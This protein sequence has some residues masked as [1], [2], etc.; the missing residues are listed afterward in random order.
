MTTQA[1]L[2]SHYGYERDSSSNIVKG[3]DLEWLKWDVTR[4]MSINSALS[5][6]AHQGYRVASNNE[7]TALFQHFKFGR[8]DWRATSNYQSSETDWSIGEDSEYNAFISLFGA[9]YKSSCGI[10]TRYCYR[11]TDPYEYTY[12]QY[13]FDNKIR[14]YAYAIVSDDSTYIEYDLSKGN[15][16]SKLRAGAERRFFINWKND[17]YARGFIGVA[18]V[19][20]RVPDTVAVPTPATIGL[21]ALGL[22]AL[23]LRRR[24]A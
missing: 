16:E 10:H 2:I 7:V 18:L 1:S 19:R 3:G 15:F 11:A 8:T 21:L 6:Y 17:D 20:N 14:D 5:A 24:K 22:V 12:A 4:G 23:G 9:T 13:H